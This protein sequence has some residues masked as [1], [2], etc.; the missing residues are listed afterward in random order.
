[1]GA[2]GGLIL[3]NK[4]KILQ[5]KAQ[6]GIQLN[7][8]RIA[9]GDGDLG[10]T[11]ILALNSL[12]REKKSLSI[13]K[14]KVLSD[15][16][17]TVGGTWSNSD[18]TEGFYFREIGVFAMDPDVGEILYCYGNSGA[19]AEYIPPS[20]TDIIER[21][22][23]ITTI[24]GNASNVTATIDSSLIY[25]STADLQILEQTINT[26][27]Q[28]LLNLQQSV[29]QNQQV[30]TTHL[31]DDALI[32]HRAKQIGLEDV[33]ALFTATNLEE[34]MKELFTNVSNGKQLVGTAITDV[35]PSVTVPTEPTFQELATAIGSISTGKK[36]ASG[37]LSLPYSAVVGGQTKTITGLSFAPR[38]ILT[39]I[40]GKA[41]VDGVQPV[42]ATPSLVYYV[43][44]YSNV[45]ANG[46]NI[47]F[48]IS[49][50]PAQ[51]TTVTW[52]AFE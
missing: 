45:S 42:G 51:A 35:D 41:Y 37:T 3:T 9:M 6:T 24:V 39:N 40:S 11:A 38:F 18:L 49:Q 19:L 22:L 8:T 23:D 12:I 16:K 33:D 7:Y 50:S 5:S 43:A 26:Q 2:F 14:L 17:A 36:W 44:S 28:N 1:M 47:N 46:F 30:V 29:E 4:G 15:G 31:A 52:Y 34:G 13:S 32:K 10:S 21:S 48:G 27:G 25:A 20:G